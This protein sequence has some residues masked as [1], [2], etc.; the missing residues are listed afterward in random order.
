MTKHLLLVLALSLVSAGNIKVTPTTLP[1]HTVSGF[2]AGASVAINHLVAFSNTCHGLGLIGG[3][4]YGCNT[5]EN[6]QYS[7]SGY[8]INPPNSHI[9]NKTIPWQKWVNQINEGYLSRRASSNKVPLTSNLVN[10]PIYLFSGLDDVFVYQSVMKAVS[11]QFHQLGANVKTKFDLYAAHSWVVDKE[12]CAAPGMQQSLNDCC[13]FKNAS[14]NCPLPSDPQARA[15]SLQGCCGICTNGDIDDRTITN[16]STMTVGWKPPINS[17]NFDMSGEILKWMYEPKR[18]IHPRTTAAPASLHNLMKINQTKYL[19][20]GW[21]IKRA[22]L[23]DIGF[24]YIPKQCQMKKNGSNHHYNATK[25]ELHVHYHPC[26]GGFQFLSV[27]YMLENA[28]PNYAES[29]NFVILYPQAKSGSDNPVGDG[30]FDWYGATDLNFDTKNGVQLSMVRNIIMD[31]AST[32]G[33]AKK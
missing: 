31:L 9:E 5:V 24:I 28:L 19:P 17:C 26:G 11:Y 2:S 21:S 14:T 16:R 29:N 7:C 8:A 13:G 1:P 3:S 12:T 6:S 30:C 18:I 32:E 4:P 22:L 15:I 10:T 25:C 33:E 27:S 20:K 23:D